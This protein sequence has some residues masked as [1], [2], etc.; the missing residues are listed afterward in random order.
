L[1]ADGITGG[2]ALE[3]ARNAI[4]DCVSHVAMRK[5]VEWIG[6]VMFGSSRVTS[7]RRLQAGEPATPDIL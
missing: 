6:R 4:D 3:A 7:V 1:L 5:L 2:D